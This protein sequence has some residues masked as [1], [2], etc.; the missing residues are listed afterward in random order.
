MELSLR[1]ATQNQL[2]SHTGVLNDFLW[3]TFVSDDILFDVFRNS[4][5]YEPERFK[6]KQNTEYH[7]FT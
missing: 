7:G 3:T 6:N 4:L 5:N 2:M 1:Y